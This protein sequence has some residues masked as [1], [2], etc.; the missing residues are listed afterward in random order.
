MSLCAAWSPA[1]S[2][3]SLPAADLAPFQGNAISESIVEAVGAQRHIIKRPRLTRLLDET[4]ARIILLVAPAGY[5]KTTLAREWCEARAGPTAWYQAGTSAADVAALA[6]DLS[7]A[8]ETIVPSAG[9]ALRVH[10]RA[11][12]GRELDLQRLGRLVGGQLREWPTNAVLV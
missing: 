5:G 3:D 4:T 8:V 2:H 11:Q 7:Y 1:A 12:D 10:L 6:A 9:Q